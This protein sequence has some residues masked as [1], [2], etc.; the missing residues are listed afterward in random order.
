MH[1]CTHEL[2]APQKTAGRAAQDTHKVRRMMTTG[3]TPPVLTGA[4]AHARMLC[5]HKL[6][7]SGLTA[8]E[9]QGHTAHAQWNA[10]SLG[11]ASPALTDTCMHAQAQGSTPAAMTHT[12]KATVQA[13][14]TV[15]VQ[16]TPLPA[17]IYTLLQ[18]ARPTSAHPYNSQSQPCLQAQ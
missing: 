12:Q 9:Q 17:K 8:G 6:K 7:A 3:S 16:H 18:R 14:G 15:S 13:A 5:T 10:G 11:N 4:C 2:Q 1:A